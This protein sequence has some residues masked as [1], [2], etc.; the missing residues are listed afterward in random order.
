MTDRV[1]FIERDARGDRV[2]AVR[3][4][5]PHAEARWDNPAAGVADASDPLGDADAAAE[6]IAE[7]LA[8]DGV[9]L[10][11]IAMDAAGAQCGWIYAGSAE[12]AA[13]RAA[14]LR[15]SE[16]DSD[17]LEFDEGF[18][19]EQAAPEGLGGI[20]EPMD[21]SIEPLAPAARDEHGA[22][23]GVVVAPDAI[24]RLVL[25]GLDRRRVDFDAVLSLWHA[26]ALACEPA[27]GA[28]PD[29]VVAESP[30][31]CGGV[32][33]TPD[34][35]LLWC[36][37]RER[38]L[39]AAGSVRL[40]PH[41]DGPIVTPADVA[42]VANDWVAWSA[43]LG[44]SPGRL[45]LFLC[46]MAGPDAV[47]DDAALTAPGLA[48][49]LADAWPDAVADVEIDD[50]PILRVL[51]AID[52]GDGDL[53]AGHGM[54]SLATRP[55][56]STRRVYT[57]AGVA[58]MALG[59][60]LGALGFRWQAKVGAMEADGQR[61]REAWLADAAEIEQMLE[62]PEGTITASVA[63]LLQLNTLVSN[64]TRARSV[65]RAP[66]K[67]V[68]QELETLTFMLGELGD[69]V[70]LQDLLIADVALTVKLT[71]EDPT[72]AGRINVLMEDLGLTGEDANV[73]WTLRSDQR[74][75]RYEVSLA[76]LW[77]QRRSTGG[78]P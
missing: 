78:Q 34:G 62:E 60:A 71:T 25:D 56:R 10:S 11:A 27:G 22:R 66:P 16:S 41:D 24:V 15:S 14:Y 21:A 39:L 33:V 67:P 58:L 29:R 73:D 47:G 7:R 50:D 57:L 31:V 54:A 55:G 20:A 42:R 76:G 70:E 38:T 12:P 19:D 5:S 65:D 17:D 43:Q 59:V 75:D 68:L 37:S 23:V 45:A 51:R 40:V 44:V 74:G 28:R 72:V 30:V 61:L 32:L 35:R 9:R 36:W 26:L 49:A 8:A 77:V 2:Q 3:L 1:C 69:E 48:N 52:A 63:P 13:V 18:D 46:P 4:V 53:A 64:A 6:W